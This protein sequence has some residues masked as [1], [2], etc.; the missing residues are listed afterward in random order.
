MSPHTPAC[1]TTIASQL[2]PECRKY[3]RECLA[4]ARKTRWHDYALGRTQCHLARALRQKW[5]GAPPVGKDPGGSGEETRKYK[6]LIEA[7]GLEQTSREI[8][9][10]LF[11]ADVARPDYLVDVTDELTL[12][13]SKQPGFDGRWT[14]RELLPAIQRAR[15][16]ASEVGELEAPQVVAGLPAS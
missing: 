1:R 8:L 16:K 13:D 15:A 9:R 6:D 3:F 5:D 10:R 11:P 7:V 12:F 4:R 2:T 14:G